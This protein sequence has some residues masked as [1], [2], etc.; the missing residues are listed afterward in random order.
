MPIIRVDKDADN[1]TMTVVAEYDAPVTRVWQ[2]YE[3]PRQLEQFWGPPTWPATVVDHDLSPGGRISYF[4][5][6]PEG[7]KAA[8]YWDVQEVDA[9]NRFLVND[10]FA[11]D[12]GAPN[13]DMPVTQMELLLAERPGGGTTMTIVSTFGSAEEMARLIE[14]GMDEG[15]REALGQIDDVL[16][17]AD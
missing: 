4:M 14:M 6:G 13:P 3:D 10:G 7:E 16:A 17:E 15:M 5:T 12:S 11:D 8:G 2:L 1:H 9:P